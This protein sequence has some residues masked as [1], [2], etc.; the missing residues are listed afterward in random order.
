[1]KVVI[2]GGVAGGMSAATRLRRRA[3]DAQ[4]VVFERGEHVSFANCGLPYYVGG[5][6]ADRRSLL[7]QTPQSLAARFRI[8]VRV[9][10]EVVAIDRADRSVRVRDLGTGAEFAEPYDA[11]VLAPG[12]APFVPDFPGA[13]RALALRNIADVDRMHAAVGEA[14]R[15]AM[16]LGAGFIGLEMAENLVERGIAV[17]VVEMADQVLAPLDPEMAILVQRR[18]EERGVQVLTG[19]Q[20]SS[21]DGSTATLADG[22]R[23]EA[24]LL[25]AAIGVRADSHLAAEAGLE[26]NERGGIVVDAQ[27]R[28]SD[29]AIYA[30]G[31]AAQKRDAIDGGPAMVP[32]AQTANRHGRLVADV[33]TGRHA[34]CLPVLGTAI[35]GMF[36]L[37]VASTGWNEKRLRAAGRPIRIIHTHP[38]NHAGYYP[39][40]EQM[41]LKLLIDADTDAILGAQGVGGAGVDK[42][43]DV[44]ATAIRGGLTASDLADLEL[45]YAPQF[46]SAKDPV[47]ML[48]FIADNLA[49]GATETIQ[50]HELAEAQRQGWSVV[51]VRTTAEFAAGA[52][53]GAVNVPVD[54]LRDRLGELPAGDLVVHCAVGLRGYIAAQILAHHGRR[55]T[56]LDGGMRTWAPM[57][58]PT[59]G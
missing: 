5:A 57:N 8:D 54:E 47:N 44:I 1:M 48:G 53:P 18:L 32:L 43:I 36:G 6:I 20:V 3:E 35:V 33:I 45:A 55:V 49:C 56:N 28:T 51:D 59:P 30:V 34:A 50:W 19:T 42:R 38:A 46:G 25:V 29:P 23:H 39:G 52:I 13:E 14:P 10:H 41:S 4:I 58:A 2:V 17:T 21:Y 27:Q 15:R 26:V 24:D 7:L 22:S 31:D 40:A 16:V 9:R 37:V 11:L 12:A